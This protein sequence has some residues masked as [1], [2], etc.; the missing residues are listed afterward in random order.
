MDIS[1]RQLRN[2]NE[3]MFKSIVESYW[4]RLHKFAQIYVL[5]REVAKEI[6]QD[7]FL[8]LWKQREKLDKETCLITYLMVICRNKCFNY[9]KGLQLEQVEINDLNEFAIYQRSNVYVLENDSLEI[10]MT[11]ELA[12]AIEASLSKLSARTRDIFMMSRYDG[13]KN[14]EIAESQ[15]ITVKAVEFHI[16]KALSHLRDDLSKEYLIPIIFLI[17]YIGLKK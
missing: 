17:L 1:I 9:L 15:C 13:F 10:L 12:S 6:V 11:K 7:T 14:K 8:D 2:S 16:N 5:D 3:Q 4:P